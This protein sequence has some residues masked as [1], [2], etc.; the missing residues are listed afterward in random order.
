M[1]ARVG[2]FYFAA[3]AR[4]PCDRADRNVA[5]FDEEAIA[6]EIG[7]VLGERDADCHRQVAGTATE[8]GE[9][10]LYFTGACCFLGQ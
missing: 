7:A 5:V 6:F 3:D 8:A 10:P 1:H 2:R 4:S 9:Q